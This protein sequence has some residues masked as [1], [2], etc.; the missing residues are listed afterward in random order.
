MI[1]D[2]IQYVY[3]YAYTTNIHFKPIKNAYGID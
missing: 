2:F 1:A 3:I